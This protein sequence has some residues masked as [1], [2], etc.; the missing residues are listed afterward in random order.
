LVDDDD[1]KV[2][3]RL[4]GASRSDKDNT[5]REEQVVTAPSSLLVVVGME[6]IVEDWGSVVFVSR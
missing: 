3:M 5:S 4:F 2:G 1:D 6:K